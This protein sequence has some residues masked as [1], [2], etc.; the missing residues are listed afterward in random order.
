[1]SLD[2]R[3]QRLRKAMGFP[4]EPTFFWLICDECKETISGGSPQE[5]ETKAQA[6]G[7]VIGKTWGSLDYCRLCAP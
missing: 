2:E 5:L 7:W 4:E 6:E 1:M 3:A